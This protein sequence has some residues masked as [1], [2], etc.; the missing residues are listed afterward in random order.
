MYKV[1]STFCCN[2]CSISHRFRDIWDFPPKKTPFHTPPL[3]HRKIGELPVDLDCWA[4][5]CGKWCPRTCNYFWC[6]STSV[7]TIHECH[8]Q[9][10]RQTD[11]HL[12]SWCSISALL[13]RKARQLLTTYRTVCCN[14]CT[15][16]FAFAFLVS[17]PFCWRDGRGQKNVKPR[18]HRLP[19]I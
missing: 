18:W 17:R 11:R 10:D 1:T 13:L 9:T 19:L 6:A 7:I 8:R 14:C 12:V 4:C 5:G 15:P 2:F 3:F 16:R